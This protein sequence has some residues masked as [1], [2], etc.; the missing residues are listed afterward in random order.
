M[1]NADCPHVLEFAVLSFS[2]LGTDVVNC[3]VRLY[4]SERDTVRIHTRTDGCIFG[5]DSDILMA[6]ED[7]LH[8]KAREM[9]HS[10]YRSG[11]RQQCLNTLRISESSTRSGDRSGPHTERPVRF[12]RQQRWKG[13]RSPHGCCATYC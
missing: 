4:D 9:G 6:L 3:G 1:L 7:D 8:C 10:D 5:A 12:V 2:P 11:W 13:I